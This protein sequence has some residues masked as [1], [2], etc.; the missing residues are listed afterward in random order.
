MGR[1]WKILLKVLKTF[2][3]VSSRAKLRDPFSPQN[4][5]KGFLY[6][7]RLVGMTEGYI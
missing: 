3:L 4:E 1:Q 5:R 7:L 6:A 2:K